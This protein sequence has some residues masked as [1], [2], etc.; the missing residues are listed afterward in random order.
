MKSI[1]KFSL[2]IISVFSF[3]T[4]YGQADP[5][6]S[7]MSFSQSIFQINDTG[8]LEIVIGNYS[9]GFS[10]GKALAPYDANFIITIPYILKVNGPLDFSKVPFNVTIISQMSTFSGSTIIKLT[11][12]DGIPKGSFGTVRIP[13]LAVKG[14]VSIL[15]ATV[16]TDFNLSYPP[17]GNLIPGN[18]LISTPVSVITPLPVTLL[19]FKAVKENTRVNL[20]WSTTSEVNSDRFDIEHSLDG[21]DWSL[22]GSLA[23]GKESKSKLDYHFTHTDPFDGNNYYRLKMVD[24]D[25]TF[26]FSSIT[27]VEFENIR[28]EIY[29]NPVADRLTIN[30]SNWGSVNNIRLMNLYGNTVYDSGKIPLPSVNVANLKQGIYIMK[31]GKTDGSWASQKIV[32]A[33]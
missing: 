13:L 17:S 2:L 16:I 18:D 29:P 20:D 9:G 30:M 5:G 1:A 14:D 15:Y 8:N 32:V 11:V 26:A 22:I 12:P 33:R 7:G 25:E 27:N 21:K 23:S 31:I 10:A 28:L 24:N 4:M 3:G 19:S 6:S